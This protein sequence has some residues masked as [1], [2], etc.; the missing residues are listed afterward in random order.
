MALAALTLFLLYRFSQPSQ[1]EQAPLSAAAFKDRIGLGSSSPKSQSPT[2]GEDSKT[3][4]QPEKSDHETPNP[5][6]IPSKQ[7]EKVAPPPAHD[8]PKPVQSI[9]PPRPGEIRIGDGGLH[10]TGNLIKGKESPSKPND[11]KPWPKINENPHIVVVPGG[12]GRVSLDH[13]STNASK[14][15]WTKLPEHYPV[16]T[17]S[18]IPLPTGKGKPIPKI[19]HSFSKESADAKLLRMQK[20][21]IVKEAFTHAW[22]GYKTFAWGTDELKPVSGKSRNTFNGWSATLV[23]ALDTMWLMGMK[24]DFEEGVDFVKAIDFYASTRLEIPV[25]ETTIRYLGGLLG[26]YDVSEGKYPVLL[27]RARD[28][29]DMLMAAF[30]TPNRMPLTYYPW[31]AA[32]ASQSHRSSRAVLAEIGSL[33]MEFTRLAQLTG[34][35]SYY[36]AITRIVDAL[37]IYQS[38]TTMPGIWPADIDTSGCAK[39]RLSYNAPSRN[40][41]HSFTYP[42]K[43]EKKSDVPMVPLQRPTPIVFAG[44]DADPNHP[45]PEIIVVPNKADAY[46]PFKNPD[47]KDLGPLTPLKKPDPIVFKPKPETKIVKR[48]AYEAANYSVAT[49]PDPRLQSLSNPRSGGLKSKTAS[50]YGEPDEQCVQGG[51]SAASGYEKYTLGSTSDSAFEY[52]TKQ[53]LL[54]SGQVEKYR[55]MY[56]LAMDAANENL[57][58]RVMIPDEKR[59]I[60]VSGEMQISIYGDQMD[61]T[62]NPE[63]SHLVC[64]V[65]GMLAMG[66]KV[67]NRPKDLDIAAKLTD[68]CVWA[69]ESTASGI[70][71]ENFEVIKCDSRKECAWNETK[72]HYELDPNA[73]LRQELYESQMENYKFQLEQLA[74]ESSLAAAEATAL[75]LAKEDASTASKTSPARAVVTE[76]Q[77][78]AREPPAGFDRLY[79]PET[80]KVER[81]QHEKRELAENLN[82]NWPPKAAHK[83]SGEKEMMRDKEPV[84]A[85]GKTVTVDKGPVNYQT[86]EWAEDSTKDWPAPPAKQSS[87]PAPKGTPTIIDPHAD[88][89]GEST[90]Q[91][92]SYAEGASPPIWSPTKPQTREQYVNDMIQQYHLKPGMKSIR[93]TR[94]LLR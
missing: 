78:S 26:A 76:A 5:P 11:L 39:N 91:P 27:D 35:S 46:A 28:L 89:E 31:R 69:Y 70:M 32:F 84:I 7:P 40:L 21:E 62:F 25:F 74:A 10:N 15:R 61:K 52:L 92:P 73:E 1:W 6:K 93:D 86:Q 30:D 56:E 12:Q 64:F 94:Y 23:D 44:K 59:E 67:F 71:P 72:W 80:D 42:R 63:N 24:K 34:N 90:F 45:L 43:T 37:E 57:I 85:S 81:Y 54:L 47:V 2:V 29:G 14:E 16:P 60:Y 82:T 53:Y 41:H 8:I 66:A 49:V 33:Q 50:L 22:T 4:T 51:L 17:E 38:N 83:S 79:N 19:Q 3:H 75:P 13:L 18:I 77:G 65:G 87:R 58:F 48:Q 88:V 9:P 20:L 55:T 36:D 68:G